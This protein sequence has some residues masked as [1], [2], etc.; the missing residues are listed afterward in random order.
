MVNNSSNMDTQAAIKDSE[1]SAPRG[2]QR[3]F[4]TKVYQKGSKGSENT[5]APPLPPRDPNLTGP[6]P[7][8]LSTVP[9]KPKNEPMFSD[10]DMMGFPGVAP[11]RRTNEFSITAEGFILTMF[12]EKM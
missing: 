10:I 3:K 9:T 11:Y 5:A 7:N 2:Q 4:R 8:R 6:K 1:S 12:L